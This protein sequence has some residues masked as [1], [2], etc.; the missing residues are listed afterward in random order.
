VCEQ[1]VL[2]LVPAS[3]ALFLLLYHLVQHQC[4]GCLFVCFIFLYFI[5]SCLV[6]I[7]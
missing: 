5:L 2:I 7:S 3:L 6:V 4:D 1:E